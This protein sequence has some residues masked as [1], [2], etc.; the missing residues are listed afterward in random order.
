MC[1]SGC[2]KINGWTFILSTFKT[3]SPGSMHTVKNVKIPVN[4]CYVFFL[5][6]IV[7]A[8]NAWFQFM[9]F[10]IF[11]NDFI[12][13]SSIFLLLWWS[14]KYSNAALFCDRKL[15]VATVRAVCVS[16]GLL[17]CSNRKGSFACFT[18]VFRVFLKKKMFQWRELRSHSWLF[19]YAA[20]A[21]K[22][23]FFLFE[24]SWW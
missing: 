19:F 22:L 13:F 24:R 12:S 8:T 17:K 15:C 5:K 6:L 1:I 2:Q 9:I 3:A 4:L 23:I 10:H 18:L 7:K 11:F 20:I 16:A 21:E 14:S